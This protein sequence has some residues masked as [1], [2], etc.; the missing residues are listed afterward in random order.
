[1]ADRIFIDTMYIVAL[2]NENDEH[3]EKAFALSQKYE[4]SSFVTTDAVLLEIANALARNYKEQAIKIIEHFRSF[5][6]VEIVHLSPTLFEKAFQRYKTYVD[7]D[8]SLVDCISFEVMH[9]KGL[10]NV[11]TGDKH[12]KQAGFNCLM[13]AK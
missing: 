6:D 10:T 11:L 7:K 5:D 4:K 9:E 1:V 12:F 2:V 8:W 13:A 3:H